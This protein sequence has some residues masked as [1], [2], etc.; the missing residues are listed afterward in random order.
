MPCCDVKSNNGGFWTFNPTSAGKLLL[1]LWLAAIWED[2]VVEK[3]I[4][5]KTAVLDYGLLAHILSQNKM[6]NASVNLFRV[7][8]AQLCLNNHFTSILP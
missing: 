4:W 6:K 7:S 5:T 3:K 1:E 8:L 2:S